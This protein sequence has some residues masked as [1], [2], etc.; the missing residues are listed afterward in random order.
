MSVKPFTIETDEK[1]QSWIK[2]R[3]ESAAFPPQIQLGAG[4]DIWAYGADVDYMRALCAYWLNEYDWQDTVDELN[5]FNHFT[6]AIDG[7]DIHFIREDGSGDNPEALLMSHGWPGSIYEFIEVIDRLAHPENH[8]GKAEDGVTVICPS[9]PGYGFSSAP[10]RPIGQVTTAALWDKLMREALGFETYIAQGGDWGSVVTGLIGL[11]HGVNKGGGCKAVHI[12]MY[13][14]QAS[15]APTSD[16]EIAWATGFTEKMQAEGAYLQLQATKP[17]SLALAMAD[18]PLGIAAWVIEK[19]HGWSD[20]FTDDGRDIAKRFTKHQL[21]SNIMI[22]LMTDSF[23]TSIWY[24]RGYFEELPHIPEGEKIEVPCG[25]GNFAEP[26]ITFPPRS[27]MA[28]DY[29]IVHW[30]DYDTVGHFAAMEDPPMF[31]AEVQQFLKK[32]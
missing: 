23:A 29:H 17:Q 7:Y 16:E 20:V 5:R 32:L 2:T 19:F 6:A 21:L 12:N 4:E 8:G 24:Y 18:S 28:D 11:H 1:R 15:K 3:I 27:L 30:N 26:Y 13:G 22:Y 9:L 31:A 14:L 25:I 10:S